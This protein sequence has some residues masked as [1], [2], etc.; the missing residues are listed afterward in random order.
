M[1]CLNISWKFIGIKVL[2]KNYEW[3]LA[4]FDQCNGL[5]R[6][7]DRLLLIRIL[8]KSKTQNFWLP[9]TFGDD[10]NRAENNGIFFSKIVLTH[11]E[12]NFPVIEEKLLKFEAE[13]QEVARNWD[14]W[15]NSFEQWKVSTIFETE[16]HCYFRIF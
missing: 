6:N 13:S 16:S 14:H 11:P 7:T 15:N 10:R 4:R 9:C 5:K 1:Y 12:T 2:G 8:G 3:K